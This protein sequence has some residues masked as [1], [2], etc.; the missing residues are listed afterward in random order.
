MSEGWL[1]KEERFKSHETPRAAS[2][3]IFVY[4][5]RRNRKS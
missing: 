1:E 2:R 5:T 4:Y 3:E